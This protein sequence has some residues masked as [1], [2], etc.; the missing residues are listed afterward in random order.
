[1]AKKK[2][3]E[4]VKAEAGSGTKHDKFGEKVEGT[5]KHDKHGEK[6]ENHALDG[7]SES[8]DD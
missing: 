5:G 6:P 1:M 2:K 7:A 4:N 8:T 3:V